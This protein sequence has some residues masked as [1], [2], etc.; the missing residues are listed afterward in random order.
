LAQ[1][2]A[3][4]NCAKKL[5]NLKNAVAL[6]VTQCQVSRI[7]GPNSQRPG[8]STRSTTKAGAAQHWLE[9]AGC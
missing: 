5:D 6:F 8:Q 2:L 3:R 1:V 7:L 4:R 9:E